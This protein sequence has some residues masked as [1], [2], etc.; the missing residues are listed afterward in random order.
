MRFICIVFSVLAVTA[1]GSSN[2]EYMG[3]RD[4]IIVNNRNMPKEEVADKAVRDKIKTVELENILMLQHASVNVI[5]NNALILKFGIL[6]HAAAVAILVLLISNVLVITAFL[7]QLVRLES[8]LIP[9]SVK[10]L[11]VEV[12]EEARH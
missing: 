9:V 1:C 7:V 3:S 8:M 4:D 6:I 11:S 2:D 5:P 10:M 12:M